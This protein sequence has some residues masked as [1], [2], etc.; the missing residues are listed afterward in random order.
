MINIDNIIG[1]LEDYFASGQ[2]DRLR[3]VYCPFCGGELLYEIYNHVVNEDVTSASLSISCI[4]ECGVALSR[5]N[6]REIQWANR[7][8][9]WKKW[10]ASLYI[11]KEA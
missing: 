7:I 1:G 2:I 3:N 4:G 6:A 9:N 8:S 11:E 10:S 5:M